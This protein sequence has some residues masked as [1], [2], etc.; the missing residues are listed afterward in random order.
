[1]DKIEAENELDEVLNSTDSM[2]IFNDHGPLLSDAPIR[3][4]EK[5][6]FWA[7]K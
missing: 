4:V 2:E 5:V 6:S 1:M 7:N 3:S